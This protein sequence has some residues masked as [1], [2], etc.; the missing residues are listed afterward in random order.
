MAERRRQ[1]WLALLGLIPAAIACVAEAIP[2]PVPQE[3]LLPASP[4][5]FTQYGVSYPDVPAMPMVGAPYTFVNHGDVPLTIKELKPSCGCLRVQMSNRQQTIA[6]GETGTIH[7]YMQTA[8]EKPGPH[9]YTID[10][11]AQGR[12]EIREQLTFRVVLPEGKL[13][14]EPSEVYFYQLSGEPDTR[15]VYLMDRREQANDDF[16]VTSIQAMSP[17]L[18]AEALPA[19]R[20]EFGR[21][22]IPIQLRVPAKV[23]AGADKTFVRIETTDADYSQLTFPV[24]IQ[25]APEI[26]GPPVDPDMLV[27]VFEYIPPRISSSG[28]TSRN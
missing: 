27:D 13:S 4:L 17:Q 11:V 23:T 18:E 20:D 16:Q 10:V 12:E 24:L 26:Y 25:G 9:S 2:R 6:P 5:G 7:A 15:L 19:E 8:N 22:R 14:I 21:R 1:R 3:Q 28:E